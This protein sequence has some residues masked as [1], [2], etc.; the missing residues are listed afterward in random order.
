MK[1]RELLRHLEK[2]G[3]QF[4][5]EGSYVWWYSIITTMLLS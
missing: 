3:C 2:H 4:K 1:R 5:R